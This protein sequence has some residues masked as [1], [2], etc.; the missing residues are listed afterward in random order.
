MSEL[1]EQIS[2]GPAGCGHY[3]DLEKD[4]ERYQWLRAR[5]SFIGWDWWNPPVPND[6]NITPEFMDSAIDAELAKHRKEGPS[7][8]QTRVEPAA[9]ARPRVS[10]LN[11]SFKWTGSANTD[12]AATF[13][14]ARKA[15]AEQQAAQQRDA[16]EAKAKV[17]PMRMRKSNGRV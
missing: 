2:I 8:Q 13:R 3:A 4:A 9:S 5:P 10:I 7:D 6:T 16:D 15:L 1:L 11:K 12:V 17:A 14:R